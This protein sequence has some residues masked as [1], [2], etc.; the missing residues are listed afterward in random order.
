NEYNL[1]KIIADM[2]Q[3]LTRISPESS[4]QEFKENVNAPVR[5][6]SKPMNVDFVPIKPEP[7]VESQTY[8]LLGSLETKCA[9]L[10]SSLHQLEDKYQKQRKEKESL[11]EQMK[12]L[13]KELESVTGRE[14]D[15]VT[16][17]SYLKSNLQ[18]MGLRIEEQTK[19]IS[20][21]SVH[22]NMLK[23]ENKALSKLRDREAVLNNYLKES[24]EKEGKI[25]AELQIMKLEQ[26]KFHILLAG[27]NSEV[28][29]LKQELRYVPF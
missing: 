13:E 28:Q 14:K 21:L 19:S 17:I 23:Q 12:H 24:S 29:K 26:E 3:A 11:I 9:K 7:V 2:E 4:N 22:N 1:E 16:T 8:V 6:I 5:D 15:Y 18:T 10:E 20:E 25:Q 27:K